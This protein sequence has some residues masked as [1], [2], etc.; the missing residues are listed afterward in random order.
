MRSV[1]G[2]AYMRR[3]SASTIAMMSLRVADH[4]LEAGLVALEEL[5]SPG[6]RCAR[7]AGPRPRVETIASTTTPEHADR[8][9]I[10]CGAHVHGSV[11]FPRPDLERSFRRLTPVEAGSGAEEG[12]DDRRGRPR[13]A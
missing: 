11:G 8:R 2:L 13:W 10:A 7:R 4:R 3:P 9:R 5:R 6:R 12:L 1:A